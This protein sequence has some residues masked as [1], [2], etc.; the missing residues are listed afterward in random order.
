LCRPSPHRPAPFVTSFR[1]HHPCMQGK[2]CGKSTEEDSSRGRGI[3]LRKDQRLPGTG[4]LKT[5]RRSAGFFG[6]FRCLLYSI[7]FLEPLNPACRVDDLLFSGNEGMT[8]GTDLDLYIL[9]GRT[10]FNDAT[11]HASNGCLFVMGM[12]TVL[13]GWP[14]SSWSDLSLRGEGAHYRHLTDK[15]KE[16]LIGLCECPWM[17]PASDRKDTHATG[18]WSQERPD[19]SPSF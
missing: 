9:F 19:S 8:P 12:Y 18:S 11:A 17:H 6:L 15:F 16:N 14:L 2:S 10:R 4:H 13:H 7:L 3:H 5:A 1:R